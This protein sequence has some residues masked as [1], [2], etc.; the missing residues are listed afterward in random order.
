MWAASHAREKLTKTT[1]YPPPSAPRGRA[2]R[3]TPVIGVVERHGQVR[4]ATAERRDLSAKGLTRFIKK[5]V[6][7][8]GSWLMTDEYRAYRSMAKFIDHSVIAH[9]RTYVEGIV[10]TNTIEG[11]WALLKRAWFG[12]HHHYSKKYM[13]LYVSEACYKYNRREHK[14]SFDH[15]LGLMVNA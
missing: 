8:E 6:D 5:H 11:F 7:P 12:S 9:T 3:K 15:L 13:D 2:T 4:A 1:I 14:C 10:H